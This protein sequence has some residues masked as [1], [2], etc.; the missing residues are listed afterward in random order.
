MNH[1][2]VASQAAVGT[3]LVTLQLVA[4]GFTA[5]GS[6][7]VVD[8]HESAEVVERCEQVQL[9]FDGAPGRRTE[10]LLRIPT[11]DQ[12][13]RVSLPVEG[14]ISLAEGPGPQHEIVACKAVSEH[15][16]TDA[17]AIRVTTAGGVVTVTGPTEERWWVYL[18]VRSPRGSAVVLQTRSGPIRIDRFNGRAHA[19][20]ANG[21]IT[22]RTEVGTVEARTQNGPV[23]V[24]GSGGIISVVTESGPVR[25]RLTGDRW[26]TGQLAAQTDSGPLELRIPSNYR[27]KMEIISQTRATW[28]CSDGCNPL[29]QEDGEAYRAWVGSGIVRGRISTTSG[30][31][32]VRR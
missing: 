2:N 23:F 14:G 1:F 5:G 31:V 29:K 3:V 18:I 11:G 16:K 32:T 7:Q 12:P 26:N 9:T 10:Q 27:S 24:Q 4:R 15:A 8:V 17:D 30:S 6:S 22:I 28:S 19:E 21:P 13:L 25:L 20:T